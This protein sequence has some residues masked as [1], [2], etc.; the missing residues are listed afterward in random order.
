MEDSSGMCCIDAW[1][2]YMPVSLESAKSGAG[3]RID[4]AGQLSH[5]A[6]CFVKAKWNK[7]L[8]TKNVT[9]SSDR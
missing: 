2:S 3:L 6:K 4:E 8:Y 9:H 7:H 5:P 1:Q